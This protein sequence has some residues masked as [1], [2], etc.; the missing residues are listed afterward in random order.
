[1]RFLEEHCPIGL[2]QHLVSG[3]SVAASPACERRFGIAESE[4]IGREIFALI[5]DS[6]VADLRHQ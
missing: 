5:D 3:V 1:M 2:S 6:A 4:L